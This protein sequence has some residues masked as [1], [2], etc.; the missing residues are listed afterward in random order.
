MPLINNL[1]L[2]NRM[3][4]QQDPGKRPACASRYLCCASQTPQPATFFFPTCALRTDITPAHVVCASP[5]AE[6][7][8]CWS[9][10][11]RLFQCFAQATIARALADFC[12]GKT[13][14]RRSPEAYEPAL[15]AE[16]H[17][18]VKA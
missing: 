6:P 5:S 13:A 17:K 4:E 10:G 14:K 2:A 12:A 9:K 1:S 8:E 15:G 3:P 16:A 18:T 7:L 11:A